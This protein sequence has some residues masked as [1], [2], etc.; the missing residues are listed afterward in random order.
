MDLPFLNPCCFQIPMLVT[1]TTLGGSMHR[2]HPPQH[3]RPRPST[4]NTCTQFRTIPNLHLV[5]LVDLHLVDLVNL[6]LVDR[7][8][9]LTAD[10]F[11]LVGAVELPRP[12]PPPLPRPPPPELSTGERE[13]SFPKTP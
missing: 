10:V 8:E 6:H 12:R 7:V 3:R 1:D 4:T 9:L 11:L 5:G 13:Q 2:I